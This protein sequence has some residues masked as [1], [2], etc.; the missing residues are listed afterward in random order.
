MQCPRCGADNPTGVTA[1]IRCGLPA[2]PTVQPDPY[3][4]QRA[5]GATQVAHPGGA[6]AASGGG[7][8]LATI[9]MVLALLGALASL[10]YGIY[11][12][13]ARRGIY[14]DIA[15]DPSSVSKSDADSS[16][17]L[18]SV[19]L[20]VAVVLV[21]LAV[22]LWLV[23]MI[24]ARRGRGGLGVTGL[25][26]VLVG[27]A[28]AVVG[29]VLLNGVEKGEAADGARDYVLVGI[30]FLVMAIGLL[31]G[32]AA[33]RRAPTSSGAAA[34][35]PPGSYGGYGD[36]YAG[37]PTYGGTP[38]YGGQPGAGPYGGQPGPVP[39]GPPPPGASPP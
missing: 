18:N 22:V 4:A 12:L 32:A 1:C 34:S 17:T 16:D 27:A 2:Y 24:S 38:P 29:A 26:L 35:Y 9:A 33:L 19:L 11:A 3:A 25:A 20:W 8:A 30:G 10:G 5:G 36:P 14:A 7:S 13:I 21:V 28:A 15:D 39:Y 37:T 31:L 6:S 23:A